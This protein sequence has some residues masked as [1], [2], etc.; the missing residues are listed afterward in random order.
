MLLPSLFTAGMAMIDTLDGILVNPHLC[1][2]PASSQ[3]PPC[4]S[5][6]RRSSRAGDSVLRHAR[7]LIARS[8][9]LSSSLLMRGRPY[10]DALGL[11]LGFR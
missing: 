1:P 10:A 7:S 8:K 6:R 3:P 4:R 9:L 11:W 2:A 5:R